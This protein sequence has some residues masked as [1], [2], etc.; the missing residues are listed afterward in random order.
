MKQTSIKN[1]PFGSKQIVAVKKII[2]SIRETKY[3]RQAF[4]HTS[5]LNENSSED[6]ISYE[7]LE[8]LGDS[9]LNFYTALFVYRSFPQYSEG[10][11]SKLKQ[12]MVQES[13]LAYLSK[14]IGLGEY[15]Q[16]GTGERK[17]QGANKISI[18]ADVFESFVA[19]LYLEKGGKT[20]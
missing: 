18:L 17:N 19:A 20:V 4:T 9:V 1:V 13:T 7:T 14:E 6:L 16:L 3:F 11:M 8:F 2:E 15:L 12:L 10:Q 5:Y